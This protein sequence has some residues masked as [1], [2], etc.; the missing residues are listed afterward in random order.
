MCKSCYKTYTSELFTPSQTIIFA[1]IIYLF[2]W[3]D[4]LSTE[5]LEP[6]AGHNVYMF[7]QK[8]LS[9]TSSCVAGRVLSTSGIVFNVIGNSQIVRVRDVILAEEYGKTGDS[10]GVVVGLSSK[11]S[12]V[13]IFPHTVGIHK[14]KF[15]NNGKTYSVTIKA[16]NIN[17]GL[18]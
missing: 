6:R 1:K 10:G 11:E 15:T 13:Y 5:I 3:G 4:T 12:S 7:G 14:G 16:K 8:T 9:E 2:I 17:E 18:I